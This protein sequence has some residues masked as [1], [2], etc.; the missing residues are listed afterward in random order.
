MPVVVRQ[1]IGVG[2]SGPA[3]FGMTSIGHPATY[4]DHTLAVCC[5]SLLG[6]PAGHREDHELRLT[7]KPTVC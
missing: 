3:S 1:D 7:M 2:S 5:G 6:A 4:T